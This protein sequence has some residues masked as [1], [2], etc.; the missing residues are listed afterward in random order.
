M[1]NARVMEAAGAAV[2]LPQAELTGAALARAV[3][4]ILDDPARMK[5]M[6]DASVGLR[7]T[8]AAEA[9]VR[10]CYAL[11]GDQHDVNHSTG[12]ARI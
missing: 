11:I 3:A 4:Q 12:A 8:D 7:R 5:T 6:G 2:V 1:K 10:E 9:I